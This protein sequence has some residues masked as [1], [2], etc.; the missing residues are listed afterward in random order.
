MPETVHLLACPTT[1]DCPI[2]D[3]LYAIERPDS[4]RIKQRLIESG[5]PLLGRLTFGNGLAR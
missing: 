3:L 5:D 2:D 4:F 1:N